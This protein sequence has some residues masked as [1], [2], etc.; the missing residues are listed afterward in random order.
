MEPKNLRLNHT[1]PNIQKSVQI[2][3]DLAQKGRMEELIQRLEP[4][5]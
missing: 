5:A 3:I 4:E 1:N 2:I